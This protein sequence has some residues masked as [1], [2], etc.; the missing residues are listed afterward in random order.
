VKVHQKR[1]AEWRL[2]R[3]RREEHALVE[4]QSSVIAALNADQPLHGLFV[5]TMA[6]HLRVISEKLETVRKSLAVRSAELEKETIQ[7]KQ[8]ERL[9]EDADRVHSR[10]TEQKELSEIIESALNRGA[11]LP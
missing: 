2:A 5:D 9:L 8:A 3:L 6:R 11:S 10:A 4:E 1:A 7:L